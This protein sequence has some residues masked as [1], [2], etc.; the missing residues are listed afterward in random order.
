MQRQI[1]DIRYLHG[2]QGML[3][4]SQELQTLRPYEAAT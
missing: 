4:S 1:T 2:M 3:F